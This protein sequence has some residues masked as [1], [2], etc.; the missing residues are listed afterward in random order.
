MVVGSRSQHLREES[1][2]HVHGRLL[3]HVEGLRIPVGGGDKA[4]GDRELSNTVL[5]FSL[6]SILEVSTGGRVSGLSVCFALFL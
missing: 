3:S 1:P 4:S 2:C 5:V 6:R